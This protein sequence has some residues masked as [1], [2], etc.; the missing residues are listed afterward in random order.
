MPPLV[1][2]FGA[3]RLIG[4]RTEPAL[5][6]ELLHR[7]RRVVAGQGVLIPVGVNESN[8]SE[9]AGLDNL[10]PEHPV[11]PAS[12]LCSCLYDLLRRFDG[13]DQLDTLGNRVRHRLFDV[14]VLSGCDRVERD[15]LVP[16]IGR[17]DQDGVDFAI[18]ENPAVIGNRPEILAGCDLGL[19][20]GAQLGVALPVVCA[21]RVL[22]PAN[23]EALELMG[24]KGPSEA[25]F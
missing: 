19:N 18:V 2:A 20:G 13:L 15:R 24:Q 12:L 22:D 14:D 9:T 5:P 1:E 10:L 25:H 17:A 8:L 23:T 4:R 11:I 7:Y 3:E 16:M 6:I 21:Q